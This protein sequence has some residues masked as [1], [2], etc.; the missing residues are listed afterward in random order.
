MVRSFHNESHHPHIHMVCYSADPAKGFL[1][2]TGIAQIKSGLAKHIFRQEL[3]ELYQKQTKSRNALNEDARSVLEQLIE[4]MRSGTAVNHRM[5]K[6]M[7]HLAERCGT[8]E[9]RSSTVTSK[10]PLKLWWMRLWT[11]WAKDHV[12]LRLCLV[13]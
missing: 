10:P 2:K 4:Q 1:T 7:E 5:E 12:S 13:A 9:A 6:L 8:L 3:T 11:S